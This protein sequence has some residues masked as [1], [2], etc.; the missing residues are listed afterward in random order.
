[1]N[2]VKNDALQPRFPERPDGNKRVG[3]VAHERYA[4]GA[5][6]RERAG[7]RRLGVVLGRQP[8]FF[9]KASEPCRQ[10]PLP[11]PCAGSGAAQVGK[12]EVRVRVD[13]P[14]EKD[15]VAVLD[16]RGMRVP[17]PHLVGRAERDHAAPLVENERAVANGRRDNRE[18]PGGAV[19]TKRHGEAGATIFREGMVF[20]IPPHGRREGERRQNIDASGCASRRLHSRQ[21]HPNCSESAKV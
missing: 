7:Q 6:L 10:P 15:A 13:E 8:A 9:L 21:N 2:F 14:G 12:L 11:F 4:G 5:E 3:D 19:E 20:S 17:A 18:N 16:G 1:M